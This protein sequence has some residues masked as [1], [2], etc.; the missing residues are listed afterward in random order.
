MYSGYMP[1]KENSNDEGSLFFWLA[2]QRTGGVP[3]PQKRK[4]LLVWLNGGP[5]CS[6]M[7]GMMTEN[8]LVYS[9]SMS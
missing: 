7:V 2:K 1:I 8:G 5:G 3:I 6:S 4:R 9:S